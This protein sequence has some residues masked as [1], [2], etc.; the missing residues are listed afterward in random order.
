MIN[1]TNLHRDEHEPDAI[2]RSSLVYLQT[3]AGSAQTGHLADHLARLYQT[4]LGD[5]TVST[6]DLHDVEQAL[7]HL[8]VPTGPMMICT[9]PQLPINPML[10]INRRAIE[11]IKSGDVSQMK[12]LFF[13]T[14]EI[15]TIIAEWDTATLKLNKVCML[16]TS[17]ATTLATAKCQTIRMNGLATI[18]DEALRALCKTKAYELELDG[19]TRIS[20]E[21]L[22]ILIHSDIQLLRL[23]GLTSLTDQQFEIIAQS[24]KGIRLDGIEEITDQQA[25]ILGQ[26]HC[27]SLSLRGLTVLTPT[28]AVALQ[29]IR[30]KIALKESLESDIQKSKPRRRR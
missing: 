12:N 24:K 22:S 5:S 9:L 28:Q 20:D 1:P 13:L 18:S 15:A 3:E 23:G 2:E 17:Q 6:Q 19:F 25:T 21:Q 16:T 29:P 4:I 26:A 10:N 27:M 11:Q 30:D 14:E 8:R 7:E